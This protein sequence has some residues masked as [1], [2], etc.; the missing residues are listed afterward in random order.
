MICSCCLHGMARR[1]TKSSDL[2]T[3]RMA[4]SRD[5]SADLGQY[6]CRSLEASADEPKLLTRRDIHSVRQMMD[7][8]PTPA[9]VLINGDDRNQKRLHQMPRCDKPL[10]STRE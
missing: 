10:G 8:V 2:R 5:P 4:I 3:S 1:L 6:C 7:C 9:L